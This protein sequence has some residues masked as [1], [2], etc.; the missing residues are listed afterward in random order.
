MRPGVAGTR[1]QSGAVSTLVAGLTGFVTGA[2]VM[3]SVA[4]V[5]HPTVAIHSDRA[6]V[7]NPAADPSVPPANTIEG[8]NWPP[9]PQ[10]G[11][12]PFESAAR[13]PQRAPGPNRPDRLSAPE[14]VVF[15]RAGP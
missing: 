12:W 5:G 2:L 11:A 4:L 10:P 7:S 6:A 3:G 15:D 8:G 9:D 1:K 14:V 13:M